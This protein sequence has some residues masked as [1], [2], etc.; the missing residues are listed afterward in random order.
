MEAIEGQ[1]ADE[2][3]AV[4]RVAYEEAV[5]ALTEQQAVMESMRGRAGL[6][7][8]AAAITTSFLAAHALENGLNLFPCMALVGFVMV[9][10]LSLAILWPRRWEFSVVP[11]K[12]ASGGPS[13]ERRPGVEELYRDLAV[14]MDQS[15]VENAG[16]IG[17]LA[18]LFQAA[19]VLLVGETV[20]WIA[21]IALTA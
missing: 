1:R 11:G 17:R 15:Y 21:S 10:V 16:A 13:G 14:N 19:S 18:I 8:T 5:R 7:L 2:S 20:L 9:C 4:Y 6:L 3:A 12:L